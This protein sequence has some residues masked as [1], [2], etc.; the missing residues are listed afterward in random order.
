MVI[1]PLAVAVGETVPHGGVSHDT[2][3]V[4]PWLVGSL[5]TVATIW[6]VPPASTSLA[7]CESIETVVPGTTKPTPPDTA[8]LVTEVAMTD[9]LKS[10]VG[11]VVG[12]V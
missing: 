11:S 10:P 3:H 5:A 12:A 4:T 9:T 7:L 6:D 2:V 8:V 1:A